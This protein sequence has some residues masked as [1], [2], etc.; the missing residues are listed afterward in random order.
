MKKDLFIS[1]PRV[2]RLWN[3]QSRTPMM[4]GPVKVPADAVK[5]VMAAG[6]Q[7]FEHNPNNPTE[8]VELT[9]ENFDTPI[10]ELFPGNVSNEEELI[11]AA[12]NGELSSINLSNP[13]ELTKTVT[14]TN[15]VVFNGNGHKI[16]M[17]GTGKALVF[18]K[19]SNINNVIIEGTLED[20]ETWSSAY[21]VQVYNGRYVINGLVAT[22]MN[23]A[24]LCGGSKV[25]LLGNVDVSGNGFGGIEVSVS[26]STDI[27][28]SLDISKSFIK[29]RTEEYAKPTIWIDSKLG[30][31]NV[32]GAGSFYITVIK[33]QHQYYLEKKN[34]Y[35]PN[36][37][38]PVEPISPSVSVSIPEQITVGEGT[39]F[40]VTTVPG[41]Y[42]GTVKGKSKVTNG[43]EK[44][45]KI[46]YYETAGD[47]G[48]KD[49]VGDSFGPS[50]G[51]PMTEATSRFRVTAQAAGEI[52]FHVDIVEAEGEKVVCSTDASTTAIDAIDEE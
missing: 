43:S 12:A 2:G 35:K 49:L 45:Q 16:T 22:K 38:D 48:W 40:T 8:K 47:A 44:I 31:G 29:N 30:S 37:T 28:P 17:K 15:S 26:E 3:I 18:T 14:F 20:P 42:I 4:N 10:T 46:E 32:F 9:E 25:T 19:D 41:G 11:A 52:S 24:L 5:S 33:D 51:F 50:S 6:C 13:I 39:E 27:K 36:T 21:G 23:A 7:I 34:T 1:T